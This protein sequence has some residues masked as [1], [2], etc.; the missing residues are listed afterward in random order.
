METEIE[1]KHITKRYKKKIALDDV[2]MTIKSNEAIALL[3]K[4]GAG[5]TTLVR[6][7]LG[8]LYQD[9][10]QILIDG[11][12]LNHTKVKIGYVPEEQGLYED[13]SVYDQLIYLASLHG[14]PINKARNEVDYWL[15]K[16]SVLEY[17]K[18]KLGALSKGNQQKIQLIQALFNTPDVLILD[19]P[20]SGVDPVNAM[21]IKAVISEQ[22]EQG[23]IILISSH[24]LDY[25]E[26]LCHKV[27]IL[28]NG[29]IVT[30]EKI[31]NLL[32]IND[33]NRYSLVLESE[34]DTTIIDEALKGIA[35]VLSVNKE[36]IEIDLLGENNINAVMKKVVDNNIKIVSIFRKTRK[37][38]DIFVDLVGDNHEF[39]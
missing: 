21:L 29:K 31:A 6:I 19:E 17:K 10:G 28:D 5:K 35:T 25:I 4:N 16:L 11:K 12:P 22:I 32:N 15:K 24:Q 9:S 14:L 37:L 26:E 27:V 34:R 33:K 8:L 36:R 7:I 30:N 2:S 13:T 38:T 39:Y 20:F 18:Y 23:K 3:G 1:I